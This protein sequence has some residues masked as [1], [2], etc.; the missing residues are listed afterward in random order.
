MSKYKAP[1]KEFDL[2]KDFWREVLVGRKIE[3]YGSTSE[4]LKLG[5]DQN[6][7]PKVMNLDSGEIVWLGERTLYSYND[8]NPS[9]PVGKI[10]TAVNWVDD[11]GIDNIELDDKSHIIMQSDGWRICIDD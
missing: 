11:T 5:G 4:N 6:A 1:W 10:I 7:I 2:N 9:S 8:P 3:A